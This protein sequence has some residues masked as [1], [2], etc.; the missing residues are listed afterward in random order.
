[1]WGGD[2]FPL[3]FLLTLTLLL[4]FLLTVLLTFLLIY[5]FPLHSAILPK[6]HKPEAERVAADW[7]MGWVHSM[8]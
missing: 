5:A 7:C 2:G 8:H 3:T 1:L 6:N 4:T